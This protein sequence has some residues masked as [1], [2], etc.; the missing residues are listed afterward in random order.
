M[1]PKGR[2]TAAI[3]GPCCTYTVEANAAARAAKDCR[4]ATATPAA[5]PF[6]TIARPVSNRTPAGWGKVEG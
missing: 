5:V 6:M 1:K 3:D 2:T 4:V